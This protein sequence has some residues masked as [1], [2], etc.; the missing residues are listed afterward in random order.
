MNI[1][2]RIIVSSLKL[3]NIVCSHQSYRLLLLFQLDQ[4][5]NQVAI[6]F[7]IR[8]LCLV[9]L[10]ARDL[11]AIRFFILYIYFICL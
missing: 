9:L 1:Y 5:R 2:E 6:E 10:G 7:G 8:K 4:Y 3:V 11:Q